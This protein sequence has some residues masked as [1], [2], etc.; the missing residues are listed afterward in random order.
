MSELIRLTGV[1]EEDEDRFAR[2]RLISWWDQERL[3]AAKVLLIVGFIAAGLIVGY[4]AGTGDWHN[5][6]SQHGGLANLKT[7]SFATSLM[8]VSFAYS[9]WNAAA[10]VAGEVQRPDEPPGICCPELPIDPG[11]VPVDGQRT[12]VTDLV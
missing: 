10:Y 1:A 7:E 8:Y 12:V 6:A 5:L 11:V 2:F 9:G 3:A 4:L